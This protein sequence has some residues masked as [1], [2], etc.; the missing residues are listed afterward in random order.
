MLVMATAA[1]PTVL[2][3][4]T[5]SAEAHRRGRLRLVCLLVVVNGRAGRAVE[6]DG[7]VHLERGA[8]QVAADV[9]G[10]RGVA[11]ADVAQGR[12]ALV[13]LALRELA[14]AARREGREQCQQGFSKPL[15]LA[16]T[17]RAVPYETCCCCCCVAPR[18]HVQTLAVEWLEAVLLRLGLRP[19]VL[20]ASL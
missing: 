12:V 10:R 1:A 18:E 2:L 11:A 3:V 14:G 7:R 15:R 16:R 13:E 8:G 17:H 5:D 20:P 19:V 9:V 4:L 6:L